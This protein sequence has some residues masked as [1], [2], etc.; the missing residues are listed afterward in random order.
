MARSALLNVMVQ[1]AMKAGR[2]LSR[3]FGEV[4][5]L[6]VSMKGPGDYVSQADRKAE[7]I[8]FAE[9]SKARPGYGFL[10]EERGAVAGDDSQHRWIVDPLDGTTNFL[11]GIPLFAVSIALERQ[12][13][14]VAGVIYNPAMDELYTTERGGGAFMNDRRLRVAGRTKLVDTVIGCG[15][16]H[17]GRGHHGNF[18]VELRNV[19]AEVSGVRRMGSASLDLAYVAAGRMDGFWE[20]G[21]SAWDIAAGLLLIREAGGFASDIDGGQDMLDTGTVVA[22]NEI[23]QRALLKTVKKP[24]PPR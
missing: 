1:A 18:L 12:G 9:L 4:Q 6:Q 21:L 22:G 5:N 24:L 20:V 16:P 3:D 2:S 13:Q 14:I 17:L 7:D 10:M 23:I 8:V 19:M 15:V 11:H